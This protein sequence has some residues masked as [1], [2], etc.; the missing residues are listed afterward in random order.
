MPAH[1]C[2]RL[3]N[4]FTSD[5]RVSRE[6]EALVGAGYRVTVV[7]D[8][9]SDCGLAEH[10]VINGVDVRR[11][12]KSSSIPYWSIVRPLLRERADIYHAHDIASLFPCLAAA[13]LGMRRAPVIYDSHELWSAHAPD[14]IHQKR[15]TLVRYEGA[16]LRAADALITASP[17]YSEEMVTRYKYKGPVA[18]VLNVPT[19]RSDDELADAWASRAQR[20]EIRVCA[21]GVFQHGRGAIPLIQ[22]LAHLPA[23]Y[24]V[25]I[26]GPIPQADYER[27]IQ[28]AAAPFGGRVRL[29]GAIAPEAIVP[30]LAGAHVSTVLIEPVSR[31]YELTAPNKLFDSMMAGTA[32]VASDMPFISSVVVKEHVGEICDVHDPADIARAILAARASSEE[33]ERNGRAAALRYNWEVEKDR[34]LELYA[35]VGNAHDY[36]DV[37]ESR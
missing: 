23:E 1:V 15:R 34:L 14:K 13:R 17:A 21:V 9:K 32:I 5:L 37:R 26:V 29:V 20:D 28:E 10:E 6:A 2:M 11:I 12:S 22:S 25:E 3:D 33:Y 16:M 35:R 36:S 8:M 4:T 18:T 27:L 7:A 19:Y 30:R 31:S 24:V